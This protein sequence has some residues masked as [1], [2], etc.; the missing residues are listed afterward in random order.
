MTP[1]EFTRGNNKIWINIM[2]PLLRFFRGLSMKL[3]GSENIQKIEIK[4][5]NLLK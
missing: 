5:R 1:R 3:M 4:L 2:R